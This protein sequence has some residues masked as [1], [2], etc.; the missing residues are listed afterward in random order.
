MN[1]QVIGP[2]FVP[3]EVGGETGDSE[4]PI[5]VVEEFFEKELYMLT[6][7]QRF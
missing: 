6:K 7:K 4:A 3:V 1:I 2:V 5:L